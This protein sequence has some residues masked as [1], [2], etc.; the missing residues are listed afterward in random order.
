MVVKEKDE[1]IIDWHQ[2]LP[3]PI[4]RNSLLGTSETEGPQPMAST[5]AKTKFTRPSRLLNQSMEPRRMSKSQGSI[6][7]ESPLD[8]LVEVQIDWLQSEWI[9]SSKPSLTNDIMT[10]SI[11]D[12]MS[13]MNELDS[14][15]ARLKNCTT[16]VSIQKACLYIAVALL[17]VAASIHCYNPFLC[18]HHA[19]IFASQGSKGGNNDDFFKKPLPPQRQCT[20]RDAIGILGRAD[21]LRAIHFSDEAMFL[22]SYVAGVLSLNRRM[23]GNNNVISSDWK[24]IGIHMYTCA[25]AVD[26]SIYSLM[27]ID[28][29]KKA[30][31]SWELEVQEEINAARKDARDIRKV[32]S[33]CL[34]D[35]KAM[36]DSTDDPIF[37]FKPIPYMVPLPDNSLN[38]VPASN[39]FEIPPPLASN[40]LPPPAV[41]LPMAQYYLP[42]SSLTFDS[43]DDIEIVAL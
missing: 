30:L 34:S 8:T 21:C 42:P 38:H 31:D 9:K 35:H 18:L 6:D 39:I 2:F 29:R 36:D 20:T 19:A 22:C 32:Y 41:T 27:D 5:L 11:D 23:D 1:G 12:S 13:K 24:A 37:S 10:A 25:I 26:T 28:T 40:Y 33:S 4:I 17:D 14:S 43:T 7:Q 16:V 3:R 15:L